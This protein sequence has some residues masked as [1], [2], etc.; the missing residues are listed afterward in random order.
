M[1]VLRMGVLVTGCP[2]KNHYDS[3]TPKLVPKL[4]TVYEQNHDK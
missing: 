2:E 3:H 1:G 4:I